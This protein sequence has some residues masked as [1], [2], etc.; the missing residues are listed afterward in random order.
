MNGN[1]W[2]KSYNNIAV[3]P[4]GA[5]FIL[6]GFQANFQSRFRQLILIAEDCWGGEI[7]HKL[8]LDSAKQ[9]ITRIP[10]IVPAMRPSPSPS[11]K[12][13]EHGGEEIF[14]G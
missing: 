10:S 2:S 11:P 12:H 14:S 13:T 6:Y 5:L 7:Q 3:L 4:V 1:K 9:L 8:M